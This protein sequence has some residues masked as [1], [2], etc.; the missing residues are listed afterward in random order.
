MEI[1]VITPNLNNVMNK[2][3]TTQ[4][5]IQAMFTGSLVVILIALVA[6]G[7]FLYSHFYKIIT[8]TEEIIIIEQQALLDP[9]KI[10]LLDEVMKNI[11]LKSKGGSVAAAVSRDPFTE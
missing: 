4:K 10:N 3:L 11:E 8:Q 2:I 9:V 1:A 6:T 5:L 7:I